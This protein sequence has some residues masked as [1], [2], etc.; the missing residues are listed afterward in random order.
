MKMVRL[1]RRANQQ[2]PLPQ[3]SSQASPGGFDLPFVDL[4]RA[5]FDGEN[6]LYLYHRQM[7]ND[8][9]RTL[10]RD[11]QCHEFGARFLVVKLRQGTRINEIVW[12]LALLPLGNHGLGKRAGYSGESPFGVV[13]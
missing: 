10:L 8:A 3:V 13:P 6:R 2:A 11:N 9:A 12:Q 5:G 4:A 1:N 7:R